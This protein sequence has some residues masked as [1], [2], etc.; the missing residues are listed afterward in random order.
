MGGRNQ[1][2]PSWKTCLAGQPEQ[3]I[4]AAA[5]QGTAGHGGTHTAL[6]PQLTGAAHVATYKSL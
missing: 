1:P 3:V 2:Q 6:D 5:W 4:Q